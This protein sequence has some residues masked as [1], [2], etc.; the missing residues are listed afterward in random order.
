MKRIGRTVRAIGSD[1]GHLR[2]A[3]DRGVKSKIRDR[4]GIGDGQGRGVALKPRD[5]ATRRQR[6]TRGA[7]DAAFRHGGADRWH[8][9]ATVE[10][11]VC[12]ENL[13]RHLRV[14]RPDR[15]A[16]RSLEHDRVGRALSDGH[17][18]F[19][20]G[21]GP[22]LAVLVLRSRR[23]AVDEVRHRLRAVDAAKAIRS[24]RITAQLSRIIVRTARIPIT[25]A[26]RIASG[27]NG[28][29]VVG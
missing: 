1:Q 28:P 2:I 4:P 22:Y 20:K 15:H 17:E 24:G 13:L 12:G 25:D 3:E 9:R 23:V 8:V 26:E 10:G 6:A 5:F 16:E 29:F 11:P 18:N 27:R 14:R 19:A 7:E 21:R